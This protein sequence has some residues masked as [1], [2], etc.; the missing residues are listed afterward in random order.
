MDLRQDLGLRVMTRKRYHWDLNCKVKAQD[1]FDKLWSL[2]RY[3]YSIDE[4][5]KFLEI[6]SRHEH[7]SSDEFN[8][9]HDDLHSDEFHVHMA[10]SILPAEVTM[11]WVRFLTLGILGYFLICTIHFVCFTLRKPKVHGPLQLRCIRVSYCSSWLFL[12]AIV[13]G[14]ELTCFFAAWSIS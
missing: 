2:R 14:L 3:F 4:Q 1:Y 6:G 12:I 5:R 8:E 7:G 11:Q 9:K 13:V 10:T